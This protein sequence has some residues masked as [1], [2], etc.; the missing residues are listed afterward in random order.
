MRVVQNRPCYY[1]LEAKW[2]EGWDFVEEV[3][4]NRREF[5]MSNQSIIDYTHAL[6]QYLRKATAR[7][8]PGPLQ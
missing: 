6:R 2:G 7:A 3:T 5:D 8:R 1:S 4:Q